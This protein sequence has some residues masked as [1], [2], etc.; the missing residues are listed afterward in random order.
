MP[1]KGARRLTKE[2]VRELRGRLVKGGETH[3]ALA[4]EYGVSAT[5]IRKRRH[6]MEAEMDMAALEPIVK[7]RALQVTRV[8]TI[9]LEILEIQLKRI[10][11]LD[12]EAVL[13]KGETPADLM[14]RKTKAVSDAL[15]TIIT[16]RNSVSLFPTMS[17][18]ESVMSPQEADAIVE[19]M[20]EE[21]RTKFLDEQRRLDER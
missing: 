3:A 15:E 6:Q 5:A 21:E 19:K 17:S 2:Q 4:R 16:A 11:A 12:A 20:S 13:G 10:R 1:R 7:E 8:N 18:G 9:I 14:I